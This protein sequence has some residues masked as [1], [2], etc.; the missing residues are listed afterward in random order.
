MVLLRGGVRVAALEVTLPRCADATSQHDRHPAPPRS[1]P[2]VVELGV[3]LST[4]G[5]HSLYERK[6][7]EATPLE[8][9]VCPVALAGI[10]KASLSALHAR[11]DELLGRALDRAGC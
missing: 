5:G 10:A 2:A 8:H 6:R 7:A 4:P 11:R 3:M 1:G 9:L